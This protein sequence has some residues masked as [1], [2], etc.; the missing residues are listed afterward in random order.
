[1]LLDL[2][3]TTFKINLPVND[4]NIGPISHTADGFSVT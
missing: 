4:A 2:I 1:M 3:S